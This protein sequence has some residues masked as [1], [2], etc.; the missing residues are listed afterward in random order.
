VQ[1]N[2][3]ILSKH[4][5]KAHLHY[6]SCLEWQHTGKP[7]QH[8]LVVIIAQE[9]RDVGMENFVDEYYYEYYSVERF[10]EAYAREVEPLG[11]QSFWPHVK[12]AAEVGAPIS[13][14]SVG[15]Q[16]KNRIKGCLEGAS[17]KKA[18]A[19]EE[20][21]NETKK[22]KKAVRGKFNCPNCGKLGHRKNSPKCRLNGTK[23][24][25]VLQYQQLMSF[26]FLN[27]QSHSFL[28]V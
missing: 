2:N 17:A 12:I 25:Q 21:G 28:C 1:D 22:A 23:K 18:S 10:K 4:V 6:C 8:A 3:N 5:V 11:D 9:F 26:H 16:R 24:R 19:K 15:R 7:C 13:K 27:H 14:R 20:S